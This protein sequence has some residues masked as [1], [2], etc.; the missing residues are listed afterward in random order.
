MIKSAC[1]KLHNDVTP[2]QENATSQYWNHMEGAL[3]AVTLE[4]CGF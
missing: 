3:Q 4:K 2:L 1:K